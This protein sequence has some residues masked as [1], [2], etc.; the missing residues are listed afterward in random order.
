MEISVIFIPEIV[1]YTVYAI[2]IR[3][4]M[5][6]IS[7]FY[8]LSHLKIRYRYR[9]QIKTMRNER[10]WNAFLEII[11]NCSVCE[12]ENQQKSKHFF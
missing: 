12:E 4:D 5:F 10:E 2:H 6:S 8:G 1:L 11:I 9:R 7:Q 3:G